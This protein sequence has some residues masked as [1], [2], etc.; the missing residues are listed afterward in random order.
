[1]F[2][3]RFRVAKRGLAVGRRMWQGEGNQAENPIEHRISPRL[4]VAQGQRLK[5]FSSLGEFL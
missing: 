5:G 1:L 4:L 3:V 2:V